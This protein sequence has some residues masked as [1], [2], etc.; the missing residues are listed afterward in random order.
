MNAELFSKKTAKTDEYCIFF[1]L[2][3]RVFIEAYDQVT[4]MAAQFYYSSE[5]EKKRFIVQDQLD[6]EEF[7][8]FESIANDVDQLRLDSTGP[9]EVCLGVINASLGNS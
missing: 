8:F 1:H 6:S 2:S 7:D 5:R 3:R 4:V 9:A